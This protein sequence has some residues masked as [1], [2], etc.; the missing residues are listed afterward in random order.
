MAI[1]VAEP[2]HDAARA[3]ALPPAARDH[4]GDV[5]W[6]DLPDDDAAPEDPPL[7]PPPTLRGALRR[8]AGRLEH[9]WAAWRTA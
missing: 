5:H 2:R 6:Y 7:P 4:P 8:T 9:R 3:A 1:P